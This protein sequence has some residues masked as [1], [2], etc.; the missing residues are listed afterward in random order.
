[1]PC[2]AGRRGSYV[3]QVTIIGDSGPDLAAWLA[4]GSRTWEA[5]GPGLCQ[6]PRVDQFDTRL[7]EVGYVTGR[8]CRVGGAADSS[9]LRVS[10]AEGPPKPFPARDDLGVP[11]GSQFVKG[12][13][14]PQPP[15]CVNSDLGA[16]RRWR[17]LG[18]NG[19]E[20][21]AADQRRYEKG[22]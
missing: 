17:L 8:Q 19:W 13:H 9:D 12:Q 10:H 11:A 7:L 21:N 20:S 22:E 4:D 18:A 15:R 2:L 14:A 3:R 6:F 5:D 1:M 16:P